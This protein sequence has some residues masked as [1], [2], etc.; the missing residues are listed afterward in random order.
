MQLR[1]KRR[2]RSPNRQGRKSKRVEEKP[3][4][5]EET[6]KDDDSVDT[7]KQNNGSND[8][9]SI[10]REF[11]T[12][13]QVR[14]AVSP[15]KKGTVVMRERLIGL[16]KSLQEADESLI[17][18]HY[19][20][21]AVQSEDK[22]FSCPAKHALQ[23]PD[24]IPESITA[25]GKF[26][27]GAK[28]NSNGGMVWAQIRIAHTEPIEN[29]MIDTEFDLRDQ[30]TYLSRQVIQHYDVSQL[31]FLKNMH[32]EVDLDSISS[33]F[34]SEM[35]KHSRAKGI[36]FGLRVKTPYDGTKKV[37][38]KKN[39]SAFNF[40]QRLQAIHVEVRSEHKD[41]A[42]TALKALLASA[43]FKKRYNCDVRLIPLFDRNSSPYTQEKIKRCIVQHGQH[44]KSLDMH[45]CDCI[46]H[47]DQKNGTLKKT[48]RELILQLTDAHFINIDLNWRR[49]SYQILY[50]KKYETAAR[51][52]IAHIGTYLHRE[53][54]DA[55][56]ESLSAEA[57]RVIQD[58][59]WDEDNQRPI[60]KL[61]QELDD[62]LT[63]GDAIEYVDL[64]L[65][66]VSDNQQTGSPAISDKFIPRLDDT[67]VSTFGPTTPTTNKE[68]LALVTDT[69]SIV[70]EVTIES[71]V[72]RMEE[73]FGEVKDML[74][75][76]IARKATS[77]KPAKPS[78]NSTPPKAGTGNTGSANEV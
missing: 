56:L 5:T 10:A 1:N 64:E 3:N 23:S 11:Y 75:T 76:L 24:A 57:Q 31:G 34:N 55:V 13:L 33:F 21:D 38:D 78:Q 35:G 4:S 46:D 59:I 19:K 25:I 60:S 14:T 28:P 43:K 17:I 30:Q 16:F 47:L 54:G 15:S 6:P 12:F 52:K 8:N 39:T 77:E 48:L 74:K 42:T 22:L 53:Y 20:T 65:L 27:H 50:P 66:K 63:A 67:S 2:S 44:C 69:Q 18:T 45:S 26:F 58:T 61:D 49:D 72:T 41:L 7:V 36:E 70:S 9:S 62:I 40:R 68:S 73:D 37:Y 51:E 29:V 71:R 32:P